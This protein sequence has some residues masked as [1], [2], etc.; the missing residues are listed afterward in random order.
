PDSSRMP[1]QDGVLVPERQQFSVL[2]QIPAGEQD[3]EAEYPA[4]QQVDDRERHPGQP[5]ITTSRPQ[6]K[7][8]I[9]YGNEYSGSTGFERGPSRASYQTDLV[10]VPA[11]KSFHGIKRKNSSKCR[12]FSRMTSPVRN[13]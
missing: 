1:A 7:A 5:T 9:S 4:N 13:Q 10:F 3:R 2:V 6:R 11:A 8:Q 12:L